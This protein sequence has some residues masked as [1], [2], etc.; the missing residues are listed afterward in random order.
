MP[1]TCP[2]VVMENPPILGNARSAKHHPQ[3]G[4]PAAPTSLVELHRLV[5]EV[6]DARVWGCVG[7]DGINTGILQPSIEFEHF[8]GRGRRQ[9][10]RDLFAAA[11]RP[12]LEHLH[13]VLSETGRCRSA[14]RL[15]P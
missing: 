4:G 10:R 2:M 9:A 6:N 12:E 3:V 15:I 14:H 5:I 8:L 11:S 13:V 7:E 1:Q